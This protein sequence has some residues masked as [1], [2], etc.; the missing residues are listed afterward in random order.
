[1]HKK[2]DAFHFYFKLW[3]KYIVIKYTVI[4]IQTHFQCIYK[5]KW[6]RLFSVEMNSDLDIDV[7]NQLT[8]YVR[9]THT[10]IVRLHMLLII[11][12]KTTTCEGFRT[13]QWSLSFK[14][15]YK[16]YVSVSSRSVL[17]ATT[18]AYNE[19]IASTGLYTVLPF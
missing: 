10:H 7:V 4:Q 12:S 18:N 5:L 15:N 6:T 11:D 3:I 19:N 13:Q 17:T 9:Y 2:K 16:Q 14:I 1:M 8:V